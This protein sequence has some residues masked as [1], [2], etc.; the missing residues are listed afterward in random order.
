MLSFV[1]PEL[2]F[3]VEECIVVYIDATKSSIN[4]KVLAVLP[5]FEIQTYGTLFF[6]AQRKIKCLKSESQRRVR[7]P[8]TLKFMEDVVP[9]PW[10]GNRY[11]KKQVDRV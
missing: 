6:Y 3:F 11:D 1:R 5:P 8:K 4:F 2:A 9:W 7:R 10:F